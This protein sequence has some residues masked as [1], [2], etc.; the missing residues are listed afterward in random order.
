MRPGLSMYLIIALA[1]VFPLLCLE[2]GR[3]AAEPPRGLRDRTPVTGRRVGT[4]GRQ[5]GIERR[6][7]LAAAGNSNS[8]FPSVVVG[9]SPCGAVADAR[10]A[11]RPELSHTSTYVYRTVETGPMRKTPLLAPRCCSAALIARPSVHRRG[12][13]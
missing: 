4:P 8:I 13:P 11:R 1:L 3:L 6:R 5:G 10:R 12:S 2:L 7:F 9:A